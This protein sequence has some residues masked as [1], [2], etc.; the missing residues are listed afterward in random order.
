MAIAEYNHEDFEQ[1]RQSEQDEKLLV[2]FYTKTIKDNPRSSEQS[3]AVFKEV[4]YV[5]IRI[6]GARGTGAARPAT[7]RDKQRFPK[8]YAAFQA[9]IELPVEGTPLSEWP[10]VTRA[11]AEEL[12]FMG[13]KTVEQLAGM[14]DGNASQFMGGQSF[15]AKANAW[16]AR[17]KKDVT[18]S[19]MEA[20]LAK[21]DTQIAALSA[22]LE[23]LLPD[24]K[25]KRK[26]RT[27]EEMK[28]DNELSDIGQR[29]FEPGSGGGGT[30]PGS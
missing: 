17:A 27:P 9:R 7:H 24:P 15:K 16:L 18:Q 14:S 6:P 29:P 13:V 26:R 3:R 25:P 8:H 4:E 10:V 19:Q 28:R 11:H 23:A 22:K 1:T 12:G 2:K 5:D 21:R 20:E 30:D